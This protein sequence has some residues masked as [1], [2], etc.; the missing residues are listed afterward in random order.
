MIQGIASAF[1]Y[2]VL[3]LFVGAL[4]QYL[5]TRNKKRISEREQRNGELDKLECP[6][7]DPEA[8][9]E[10]WKV[11]VN[12]QMHFNDLIIKFRSIVLSVFIAGIGLIFNAYKSREIVEGE[13]IVMVAM[14]LVFWLAC[15][16]LDYGYY[17]Q[18][19]IGA[20]RHAQKFDDNEHFRKAGH[21]G[22]TKRIAL[23]VGVVQTKV[24]LWCFYM[25][26]IVAVVALVLLK[27]LGKI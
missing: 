15:F 13:L 11:T 17:H 27:N 20:V 2:V 9:M 4:M 3:G 8:C 21:F 25:L 6:E 19:L 7:C 14:A 10:E 18:L 23:N 24:V 1:V 26:P 5:Y 16:L 22:L 12:T